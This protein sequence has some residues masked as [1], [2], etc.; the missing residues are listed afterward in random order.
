MKFWGQSLSQWHYHPIWQQARKGFFFFY[1]PQIY[2]LHLKH[3]GR[4]RKTKKRWARVR[5]TQKNTL[6]GWF[7]FIETGLGLD[8]SKLE[9]SAFSLY[10]TDSTVWNLLKNRFKWISRENPTISLTTAERARKVQL[11]PWNRETEKSGALE[12]F[13]FYIS[14]LLAKGGML[15]WM[16]E[17][18][19][20]IERKGRRNNE[21]Q[22]QEQVELIGIYLS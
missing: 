22:L 2:F 12:R 19:E 5:M 20:V 17:A 3:V 7:V 1:N 11:Q 6:I 18:E 14:G 4:E 16:M 10:L 15:L 8:R 21:A 13:K 9:S